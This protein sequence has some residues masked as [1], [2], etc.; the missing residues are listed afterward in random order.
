MF[1]STALCS[2]TRAALITGRNHHSVGTGVVVEQAT[3]FPGYNSIIPRNCATIGE[4]LKQ[5]GYATSWFGKEHNTPIWEATAN[6]PFDNW[7]VGLGFD[8]FYGF[9][10]GDASQWQPNLFRNTTPIQPYLGKPGW[11]LIT[12]MA[13]D[14]IDW[15]KQVKEIQ[16]DK[17]FFCYYVPGATHAPHHPT[18]EWIEKFKGKFDTGWNKLREEIF[19]NQQKLGVIPKNAQLTPWPDTLKKWDDLTAEEKKL[20]AR[21]ME[22]YAAYL[23]YADYEIGRMIQAVE[24][25]GQLDNT[26]IIYISGDNGASPEGT[27]DGSPN[28]VACLNGVVVPVK[29]QM[30]FYDAWGS[31][32]T[33]PHFAVAW[34]WAL[35]TPF[36][37]TKEVASHFGGT[38]QGMCIAWPKHIKD[39]GG[40]R[41]QF[42]HVIDV[43]PT[44]LDACGIPQ[45]AMVNGLAQ[46]PIEGVSMA[47]TWNPKNADAPSRR[48]TQYFEMF[49]SRALYHEGWIASAPPLRPPWELSTKPENPDP[50]N[51]YTWELYNVKDDPT[52]YTDLAAKMPDKLRDL[53]ELF[54]KEGTLY[55]VFPLDN[56]VL[57]RLVTPRP[58]PA[59]PPRS[60]FSYRGELANVSW[61]AAPPTLD[62]SFTITAEV[63]L[64]REATEGML[65][66]QGGRFGGYGFYLLKGKP[67]FLYNFFDLERTRWEGQE[68]LP[69]GKHTLVFDWKYDGPG[70][71]KAGTGVL[72]VDGQEVARKRM[73]H[74]I[75]VIYAW[76]EAFNV[77]VDTGTPVDDK[78][79]QVP[80]PFTGK[81][82]QLTIK[83]G[84]EQVLPEEKQKAQQPL[85]D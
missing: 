52:Q 47:Y 24:D 66:T 29:D 61:G 39:A 17:P 33:Y 43:V 56:Q 50:M 3:G 46:K 25:M 62:R 38:R 1:H 49:G 73:E 75:P 81:I 63:D 14:A 23:A 82:S 12:A 67:V 40:I 27:V 32:Q 70:F 80:F 84:P 36:K 76:D 15:M 4:I 72:T 74:S 77:G 18:P 8:Y 57:Q 45:P 54:T 64:P 21:Q 71:G 58:G 68:A 53:K 55:N 19:A 13:D 28:E 31:D 37:W 2:P 16:P 69:G 79:Y 48:R 22:V 5:N 60:Q 59:S 85:R 9:V 83:V 78:D 42:H 34:A 6:G 44:I 20:F 10:G 51:G 30:K 41:W 35:D 65:V 7:P 26:L 11:N